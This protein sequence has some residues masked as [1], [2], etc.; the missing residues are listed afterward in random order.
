M[1]KT[2]RVFVMGG[3][4]FVGRHLLYRLSRL[5]IQTRVAVRR[6][7]RVRD[8]ALIPGCEVIEVGGGARLG[9]A[10]AIAG[11]SAVVNLAGI[12]HECRG[13][14]FVET[15]V[16]LPRDLGE[17]TLAAGVRRLIHL[18][19]LG[20][21]ESAPSA[22]L[23]S[24][25]QGE[26]ALDGLAGRGLAVTSLRP[27]L[28]FGPGDHLFNRLADLIRLSPLGLLPLPCPELRLAP[29]YVGDVVQAI[30]RCLDS[31][32]TAGRV[33]ELC[34]PRVLS[35]R[36]LV[37]YTAQR[38]GRRVQILPLS[39]PWTIRL[40]A[41]FER[42][43]GRPLTV[44]DYWTLQ[45]MARCPSDGLKALGIVPTDLEAVVPSYL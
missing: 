38:L 1:Y 10:E 20:A 12:L 25:W 34:G 18:S 44:E 11:C 39:E 42:L 22:Y 5:G 9:L 19:A 2:A 27:A 45:A 13:R 6:P 33:Y 21:A 36:D 31:P 35:L 24:K 4:G 3:T 8:L 32:E 17:A 16:R 28:I 14:S 30:V 43:P 29:V 26:R 40:L 7:H 41:L 15:H 23:R 37:L